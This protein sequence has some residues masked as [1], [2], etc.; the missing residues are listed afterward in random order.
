VE[1]FDRRELLVRAG[2]LTLAAGTVGVGPALARL[3]NLPLRELA[4]TLDGTV[5]ARGAA[6]YAKARLLVSTRFDAV[7]PQAVVFCESAADVQKTVH[8]ARRHHVHVVARSG[9]HSYGGY[10]T[11]PGVVIDVSRI[12]GV[13]VDAVG[14]IAKVGAG[15]RLIDIYNALWLHRLTIPA[16]SCPTVGIAGL[17]LGGGVGFSAR[18]LG[19]TCDRLRSARV[20]LASG[21]AVHCSAS[22]HRDLFWALRGGGGGNFGIVTHF[23]FR[24]APVG[25]VST[26]SIEW[27]WSQA[28]RAVA[29]WQRFAPHAPDALFSICNVSAAGSGG[30]THVVAFGQFFGSESELRSLIAPL[31]STGTPTRVSTDTMSYMTAV[32]KWAGCHRTLDACHLVPRGKLGRETFKSGSDYFARP[33]PS[34][35]LAALLRSIELRQQSGR[36]GSLV[37]DASGGAIN[38]V[39][40]AATAFVH[41][42]QLFSCQYVA[43]WR[44]GEP[45]APSIEWVQRSRARMR[46]FAS[47]FAY[48]NYIDPDLRHWQHAYYGSNLPRLKAVKRRYDPGNFFRFAQSIPLR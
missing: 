14:H 29:A 39:P 46:P 8:W 23:S 13:H 4:R 18:K 19:L 31:V 27:P 16:G 10:S 47:G 42:D 1:R 37:L 35:G 32:M 20:V 43:S 34:A 9:G 3:G 40:K 41:R 7:H 26:F 45:G 15:A 24:P 48:Q 21:A 2:G 22:E 17:T 36:P 33:L 28:K 5:V 25:N 11:T 6:G 12:V 44:P 30:S 38:R